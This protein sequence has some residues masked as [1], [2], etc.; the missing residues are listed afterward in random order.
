MFYIIIIW[1]VSL[2]AIH[3]D[4]LHGRP[5]QGNMHCYTSDTNHRLFVDE[6]T[7]THRTGYCRGVWFSGLYCLWPPPH[8]VE[9]AVVEADM[10]Y[11]MHYTFINSAP[12]STVLSHNRRKWHT[13]TPRAKIHIH[14]LDFTQKFSWS[15]YYQSHTVSGS[16][17]KGWIDVYH[18]NI[19]YPTIP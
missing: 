11:H 16:S 12:P 13:S 1:W 10:A 6:S 7:F 9:A 2:S 14:D 8:C 3:N 4:S 19:N 15:I 18:R 17:L 5:D